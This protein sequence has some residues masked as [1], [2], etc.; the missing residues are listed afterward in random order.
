MKKAR[1]IAK[2]DDQTTYM[3]WALRILCVLTAIALV[4]QTTGA[5]A[6]AAPESFSGLAKKLLPTVVN[7]STTQNVEGRAVPEMPQLPP[8]SPI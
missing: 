8:G 1:A 3:N 4:M 7:I 5:F 6:K 2:A